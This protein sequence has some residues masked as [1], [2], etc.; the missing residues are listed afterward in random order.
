MFGVL[1]WYHWLVT[2]V[3]ITN[4]NIGKEIGANSKNGNA[5]GTNGTTVTNQWYHWEN[6]EHTHSHSKS[7]VLADRTCF[8]VC[9][10]RAKLK[11]I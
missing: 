4:G 10:C 9:L 11:C 1:Q 2:F 6:S 7:K 8:S 5:I 3:P